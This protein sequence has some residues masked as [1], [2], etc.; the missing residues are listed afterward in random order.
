MLA[1]LALL[2]IAYVILE[3][4]RVIWLAVAFPF[5]LTADA[6]WIRRGRRPRHFPFAEQPVG[7]ARAAG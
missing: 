2:F 4:Y 5:R 3:G 1:L 6:V 7:K